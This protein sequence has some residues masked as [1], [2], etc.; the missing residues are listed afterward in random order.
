M[1]KIETYMAAALCVLTGVLAGCH[2]DFRR[3]EIAAKA[4][5]KVLTLAEVAAAVP[6]GLAPEDSLRAILDYL[7]DNHL[8][9]LHG[10]TALII[11]PGYRFAFCK[12]IITN[13]H[14]PKSTLLL[15]VSALIG[16]AWRKIYDFAL[17]NGFRFLSY[18]DSCLFLPLG[19]DVNQSSER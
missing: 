18:G 10:H 7:D 2:R 4:G 5:D 6:A 1:R 11:A 14:Q 19:S 12:G 16:P 3:S 9:E 15:L 8:D 13:F 17:E